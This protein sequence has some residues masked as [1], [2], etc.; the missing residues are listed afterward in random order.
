MDTVSLYVQQIRLNNIICY[1]WEFIYYTIGSMARQ[2]I[3]W[4]RDFKWTPRDQILD[5]WKCS[6]WEKC[7]FSVD[8]KTWL[9]ISY[10]LTAPRGGYGTSKFSLGRSPVLSLFTEWQMVNCRKYYGIQS[11]FAIRANPSSYQEK[12]LWK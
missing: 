12:I 2:I 8:T 11:A 9:F 5:F 4:S 3:I 10:L 1:V 6:G 7:H